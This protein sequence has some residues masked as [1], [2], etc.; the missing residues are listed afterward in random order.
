MDNRLYK[1][2]I[3]LDQINNSIKKKIEKINQVSI[4]IETNQNKSTNIINEISIIRFA[5]K[6]NIPFYLKNNFLKCIKNN[7]NGIFID[8]KTT[9]RIRPILLKKKFAIIGSAHNQLEYAQKISQHCSLIMLSPIFQ[10]KKYTINAILNVV[11]FNCISLNWHVEICALGGLNS[12]NI[13]K[14]K[15]TKAKA[16]GFK[17]LILEK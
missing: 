4:I 7:A 16:I 2:Y 3:F 13:R 14:I 10:N 12:K 9:T 6:N 1:H 5:K 11:K 8:S 17:S 15:L